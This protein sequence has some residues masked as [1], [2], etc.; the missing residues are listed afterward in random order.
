VNGVMVGLDS[1]TGRFDIDVPLAA[2]VGD[3][4]ASTLIRVVAVDEAGNMAVIEKTV[5]RRAAEEAAEESGA[6]GWAMLILAIIVLVVA[7]ILL[8]LTRP[9]APR[10]GRPEKAAAREGEGQAKAAEAEGWE[11]FNEGGEQQ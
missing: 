3:A 11:E 5:E 2:P 8:V 7:I 1:V 10:E 6:A 4:P 9:R